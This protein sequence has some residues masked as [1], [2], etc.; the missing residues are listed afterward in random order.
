MRTPDVVRNEPSS[1]IAAESPG[2]SASHSEM[3]SM[4]ETVDRVYKAI[5]SLPH[6]QKMAIVMR[7][8][9]DMSYSDIARAMRC[10]IGTV[11]S[12]IHAARLSLKGTLRNE[13]ES[14]LHNRDH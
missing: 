10:S 14:N 11:K 7:A 13:N 8:L 3:A 1:D 2:P 5:S 9:E 12:R 4:H 6:Q